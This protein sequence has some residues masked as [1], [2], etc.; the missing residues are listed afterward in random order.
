ML[1]PA[2]DSFLHECGG[3]GVALDTN[4]ALLLAVGRFE[5][6]LIEVFKRTKAFTRR[7]Y[8]MLE[9]LVSQIAPLQTTP[10]V[11]SELCNLAG[12]LAEPGRTRFLQWLPTHI[13]GVGGTY[14]PSDTASREPEFPRLELTDTTLLLLGGQGFGVVTDDTGLHI[15]LLARG[16]PTIN[17][18]HLRTW[19]LE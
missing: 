6:A 15:A 17:F 12:Q 14:H 7:D 10:N 11:W 2:L 4:I 8:A 3:K 13:A 16:I 18:N 9:R 5:P 19:L 1:L